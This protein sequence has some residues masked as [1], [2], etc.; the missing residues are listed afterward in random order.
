MKPDTPVQISCTDFWFKM[1]EML[2]QNWALIDSLPTGGVVVYFVHDLS[3]VFDRLTY[4][5]VEQAQAALIHNGFRRFTNHP[6]FHH[7]LTPPPPPYTRR[8]HPNGPIYSSGRF[9]SQP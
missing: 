5:S 8:N 2:Q 3:G 9:W 7:F 6:E 4:P 1:V